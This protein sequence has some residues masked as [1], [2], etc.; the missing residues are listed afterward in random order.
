MVINYSFE[1]QLKRLISESQDKLH[2]LELKMKA[3]ENEKTSI[4]EA[5]QAF[6]ITLKNYLQHSGQEP[7]QKPVDWDNILS[8]CKVHR[9]RLI[10]IAEHNNGELKLNQ[11]T[12]ILYSGKFIKSHDRSNAYIIIYTLLNEM[13]D[14]GIFEKTG[15]GVYRL[16]RSKKML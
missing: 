12:D 5:L 6:E 10:A 15:R 13:V 4:L 16:S 11:A 14:K 8:K 1:E 3:L 7:E 9:D 2:S